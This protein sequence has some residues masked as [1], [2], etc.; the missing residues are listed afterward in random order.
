M[1]AC[2]FLFTPCSIDNLGTMKILHTSDWHLGHT[3]YNYD[4]TEE[5]LQMI[6]QMA[7]IVDT[8]KPDVFIISGDVY[9]TPQP[10]AATQRMFTDGLVEIHKANP[11][12]SIIVTAGNH[13]SGSKHDIFRNPWRALNVFTIGNICKEADEHIIEIPDKGFVIAIP[14]SNERNIP[15][16]FFQ[17]LLDKVSERNMNELPVV[18]TAHTTINGCDFTGHDNSSEYTVGGIDYMQLKEMG[19]GYDYLALGH[20]HHAQFIHTGKHNVRYSGSPLPVSFDENFAHTVSI[21]DIPAHGCRPDIYEKE[22][23]N[24]HPLVTLPVHGTATFYEALELLKAFPEDI[25]A[26][27]RLNVE[28]EDFLHPE[29]NAEALVAAKEKR[30]RFCCMN[31]RRSLDRKTEANILSIQE[32]RSEAPIEI[33]RRYADDTGITFDD[34]MNSLFNEVIRMVDN[35]LRNN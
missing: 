11:Q 29:A 31:V 32:F 35:D 4:R 5:Q 25:P 14:Y 34:D 17:T 30:C 6:R 28:T 10:S 24:P 12:M 13:D 19:C 23:Y 15:T 9:H 26:Y 27:I 16:G 7:E 3:L 22:I 18:M 2:L 8:H 33:A 1:P 20:I 21:V